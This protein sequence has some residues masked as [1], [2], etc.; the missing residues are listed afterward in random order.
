M[1]CSAIVDA[2]YQENQEAKMI[3]QE[4]GKALGFALN[5][6]VSFLNPEAVILYG[7]FTKHSD[8]FLEETKQVLT[9][10]LSDEM[11]DILLSNLDDSAAAVGATLFAADHVIEELDL[12]K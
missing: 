11:P 9:S 2:A 3:F 1:S 6:A 5:N 8:L 12:T 4:I 10:F 7:E